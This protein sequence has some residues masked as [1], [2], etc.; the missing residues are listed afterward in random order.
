LK[1][2]QRSAGPILPGGTVGVLGGGQLGRMF[3]LAAAQMGYRVIGYVPD[4]NAP[5][6]QVC[7]KT[8]NAAYDDTDSLLKFGAEV[9]VV[10]IEFEN[11]PTAALEALEKVVPVRPGPNVLHI[12]QN[13]LR[14]KEFLAEKNYPVV[15]FAPVKTLESLHEAL[16]KVGLPAVLKTAG[17]GYDGKGQ[18]V[19]KSTEDAEQAFVQLA[20][21]AAVIERFIEFEKELSVIGARS[22]SGDF[23]A[24]GPIENE[25]HQ[26][27]LDLSFAPARVN[28][29][30]AEEAIDIT[31][32]LMEALDVVGLLCVEFFMLPE[33]QLVINELAPRP[34]NSGHYSIEGCPTSQFE[35]QLRAIT[36]LPLGTTETEK[37]VAMANILGDLWQQGEP[38]W[39]SAVA[40]PDVHLHLYGKEEPRP[41]RKMGHLTACAKWADEAVD[42]VKNARELLMR[43]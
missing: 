27:I 29:T 43:S 32:S 22:V 6:S 10:T 9:D 19:I 16:K 5:I 33:D 42:R 2:K 15:P 8:F 11:I 24:Y 37:G 7:H 40:L 20:G 41:G 13:R 23:V 35:Q 31:R 12:T 21:Q 34:H 4:K 1:R 25:H 14:E 30:L 36:G 38:D 39:T 3:A 17:Y 28:W 18:Q 26:R